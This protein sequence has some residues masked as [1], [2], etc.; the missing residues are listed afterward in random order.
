[1]FALPTCL[2][3]AVSLLSQ[4][5]LYS[6]NALGLNDEPK[7]RDVLALPSHI[8]LAAPSEAPWDAKQEPAV[9]PVIP[10]VPD[11]RLRYAICRRR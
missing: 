7:Y 2:Q 6:N 8:M 4:L 11:A 5:C 9:V 10:A 1:M 3:Y